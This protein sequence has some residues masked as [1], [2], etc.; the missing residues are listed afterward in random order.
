MFLK[1]LGQ[2]TQVALSLHDRRVLELVGVRERDFERKGRVGA[3]RDEKALGKRVRGRKQ[4][5]F[6]LLVAVSLE[7][8]AHALDVILGESYHFFPLR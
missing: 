5:L 1:V 4:N 7:E 2:C 3:S 8:L 6:D